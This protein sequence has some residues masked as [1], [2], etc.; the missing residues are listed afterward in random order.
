MEVPAGF[1]GFYGAYVLILLLQTI[2]RLKQAEM[3][4]W[5]LLVKALTDMNFK[6]SALDPCIY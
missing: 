3:A 6:R 5:R 1:E 4:Y 2:Y